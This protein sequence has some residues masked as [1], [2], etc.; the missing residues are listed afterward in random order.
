MNS[1]KTVLMS[2][3]PL[4]FHG[5]GSWTVM[6][7]YHLKDKNYIDYIICPSVKEKSSEHTYYFVKDKSEL[8]LLKD[9]I[10]K[11]KRFSLYIEQLHKILEKEETIIVQIIDNTGLLYEI[12][13]FLSEH[14]LSHRVYLQYFY[15]GFVPFTK[16]EY[17]YEKIDE[18]IL[19]SYSSYKAFKEDCY[20]LPVKVTVNQNGID[21][22]KFQPLNDEKLKKNLRKKHRI[23]NN[24][25]L[26]VWCS[27]DKKKK[28]LELILQVW[29]QLLKSDISEIE[30]IVIGQEKAIDIQNVR[31]LGKIPNADLAEY[32]QMSD[33]YLFP[34]LWK[35]G[36]GLSLV[37]AL[38]SGLYC[39]AS[40]FGA[41][42]EVLDDGKY[43]KLV[44]EPN[45]VDNWVREIKD[46]I[47][48]F[49]NNNCVNPYLAHIPSDIYDIETWH[50]N[51]NKII[52]SAKE[53]FR[54][55][56]YL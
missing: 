36:F 39:I 52:E 38:K 40:D 13:K 1:I 22:S 27:K 21:G 55:K 17:I 50:N 56:Y 31:F 33:F 8:N 11:N 35:E 16:D 41:V 6:M 34:T 54:L 47:H 45:I 43:G 15:H 24:K 48:D 44:A 30:L 18:L 19:L 42:R 12:V 23:L 3:I 20:S 26:F 29:N 7:N 14:N 25:L 4:P 32:Y 37:E 10:Y 46:S 9:K 53:N 28:G 2:S 51:N 49:N 5:I